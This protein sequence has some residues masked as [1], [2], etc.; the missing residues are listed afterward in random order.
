MKNAGTLLP[1]IEVCMNA[2]YLSVGVISCSLI[3][4]PG[5]RARRFGDTGH[6]GIPRGLVGV[7]AEVGGEG[8]V[9]T[10]TVVA[11]PS[12]VIVFSN[13]MLLSPFMPL[14]RRQNSSAQRV[15]A[16]LVENDGR[17]CHRS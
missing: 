8:A 4:V 16:L 13:D 12:A 11:R 15:L 17:A 6:A 3:V 9:P 7:E 5:R 1:A 14:F 10:D 2:W